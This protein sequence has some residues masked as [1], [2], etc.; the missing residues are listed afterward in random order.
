M[1]KVVTVSIALAL[2]F[3]TYTHG[4]HA[5]TPS[6]AQTDRPCTALKTGRLPDGPWGAK[7]SPTAPVDPIE[8]VPAN[9]GGSFEKIVDNSPQKFVPRGADYVRRVTVTN[10]AGTLCDT[11][12]FDVGSTPDV[13]NK[14]D[15]AQALASMEYY[16]Y[17]VVH[18]GFNQA[19]DGTPGTGNPY[20]ENVANF[21]DLARSYNIRVSMT[22]MSLPNQDVPK[23]AYDPAPNPNGDINLYYLDPNYLIAE[24]TYVSNLVKTLYA[25]GA[26]MGDIFSFELQG[27][28][29][30]YTNEWPLDL[31]S[32]SVQTTE[33]AFDMASSS[34]RNAMIDSNTLHW[35]NQ[36]SATIRS[37]E[38]SLG[39]PPTLISVGFTLGL[40]SHGDRIGRPQ[41]SLSSK[42]QVDF[43]DL[44]MYPIFG[45]ASMQI[46]SIGVAAKTVDEPVIMGEFGEYAS[47]TPK[48]ATAANTLVSWEEQSC[49]L[50]GFRFSG[51]VTWTWNTEPWE[52]Q[53]TIYNMSDDK[54][55][56]A[57][58]LNSPALHHSMTACQ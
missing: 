57:K 13:Y 58:A 18:V 40:S 6:A 47:E 49:D 20:W 54:Y 38:N 45:S 16:G 1:T 43:V 51:W 3:L 17:N 44:H 48:V 19:E 28:T 46:K 25:D 15:A 35:E 21:I 12:A 56:I 27:E 37:T 33:G 5:A 53:P 9:G 14:Q 41:S 4:A 55:A 30:F 10:S 26:N 50:A 52:Q 42:S 11:A 29:I 24:E 2:G 39:I 31:T 23:P 34:S 32:Q 8:T 7:V 36:L 22:L